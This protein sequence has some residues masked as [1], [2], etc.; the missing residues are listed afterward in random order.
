MT[1]VCYFPTEITISYV[2]NIIMYTHIIKD[3]VFVKCGVLK[4]SEWRYLPSITKDQIK[5]G[6][7]WK[8]SFKKAP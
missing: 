5:M 7:K 8:E 2:P 1:S 3:D 4:C 6:F